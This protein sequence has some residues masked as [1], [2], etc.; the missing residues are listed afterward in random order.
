[1]GTAWALVSHTYGAPVGG[2]VVGCGE[3]AVLLATDQGN[4]VG[5]L[6]WSSVMPDPAS[7]KGYLT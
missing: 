7:L 2:G 3:A 4:Q 5:L 1:M 6:S